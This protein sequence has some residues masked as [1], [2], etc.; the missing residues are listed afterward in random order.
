M[1]TWQ[2]SPCISSLE[3]RSKCADEP[4]NCG[5]PMSISNSA[6][7]SRS[8]TP[9]NNGQRSIFEILAWSSGFVL[10]GVALV[11]LTN[12]AVNWSSSDNY[13]GTICH[14]MIWATA[15]Y[16]QGPHYINSV[17]VRASCGECH[18]P[19]DSGHATCSR[20]LKA[21]FIQSRPRGQG[22]LA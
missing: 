7:A 15:A 9:R 4:A 6:G 22:F 21:A 19:Y 8:E 12:H 16:H 14:S 1:Q 20:I 13:C 5:E 18:I 2:E 3:I 10:L 17:G 11:A